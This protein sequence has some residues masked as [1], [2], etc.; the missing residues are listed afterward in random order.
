MGKIFSLWNG[1]RELPISNGG[2]HGGGDPSHVGCRRRWVRRCVLLALAVMAWLRLGSPYSIE[3]DTTVSS[4]N[5]S[6]PK[7]LLHAH[8]ASLRYMGNK[9]T[10][11][12]WNVDTL[13]LQPHPNRKARIIVYGVGAGEDISWDIGMVEEYGASVV[14]IDPT[15]KAK[16]H[17]ESV[18]V[19]KSY[20][21]DPTKVKFLAEGLSHERGEIV[22]ALPA[23]RDHVSMRAVA[24]A[25]PDMTR[26]V[27]AP[28]RTLKD[29]MSELD[30]EYLD[31]LKIDIEGAEYDVLEG[32][33][34]DNYMPFTQ[35][36]VEYHDRFLKSE[37]R[38]QRHDK[39]LRELEGAGFIELWSQNGGQERGYIKR[40]DLKFCADG[41]SQRF[42]EIHRGG[43]QT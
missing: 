9:K 40:N 14:I 2:N 25:D 18:L 41:Q 6:A 26:T 29:F 27:S 1:R 8:K 30:H 17:V 39:L 16:K 24:M 10:N 11:T 36:L 31:V 21:N 5:P 4:S 28:V 35:L 34:R 15:E 19:T 23:N 43:R 22:F 20:G 3:Q 38:I 37:E 7:D 33:I 42:A 12:G 32:L 13:C